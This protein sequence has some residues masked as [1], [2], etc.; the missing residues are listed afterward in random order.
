MK[1]G[2]QMIPFSRFKDHQIY[3]YS[4]ICLLL[5][6]LTITFRF[7]NGNKLFMKTKTGAVISASNS[8]T[9]INL[10]LL[11][12]FICIRCKVNSSDVLLFN[13]HDNETSAKKDAVSLLENNAYSF[14]YCHLK[15]ENSR[16][17]KM[18]NGS[19]YVFLDPNRIFSIEGLMNNLKLLNPKI[20]DSEIKN[21][22]I[23]INESIIFLKTLILKYKYVIALHNNT[24]NK[25]S[26]KSYIEKDSSKVYINVK[27]DADNFI[28][29][30]C[31]STYS[32]FKS[33]NINAVF[34]NGNNNDDDGSMIFFCTKNSI[35]YLNIEMEHGK[36]FEYSKIDLNKIL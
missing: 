34:E 3:K 18:K 19:T 17:I 14:D 25:F 21:I 11:D 24:D 1:T 7:Y 22:A 9:L 35:K 31:E 30:N 23:K 29:T 5:I 10:Q 15:N 6:F 28:I 27:E 20:R 33:Y 12:S 32:Y 36:S 2:K 8:D 26:I 13:I 4:F 16:N